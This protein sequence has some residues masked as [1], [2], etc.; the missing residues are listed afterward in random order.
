[1]M[2]FPSRRGERAF[3][4]W[5]MMMRSIGLSRSLAFDLLLSAAGRDTSVYAVCLPVYWKNGGLQ[6]EMAGK[7]AVYTGD[8]A[9]PDGYDE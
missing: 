3:F 7:A 1:M 9:S 6:A 8:S 5:S 4:K 2:R